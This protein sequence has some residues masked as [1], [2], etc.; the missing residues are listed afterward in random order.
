MR[1]QKL[2][3][4]TN[5]LINLDYDIYDYQKYLDD[6]ISN[7][8]KL[9]YSVNDNSTDTV[10]IMTIHAS[11]GLEFGVCYYGELYNRFNNSDAISKYSYDNKYVLF[12]LIKINSYIILFIIIL[13]IGIM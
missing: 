10:K 13:V 6:I 7:N 12:F 8:L 11:K 3:E 1:I 5:S 9:E 4:I 2:K